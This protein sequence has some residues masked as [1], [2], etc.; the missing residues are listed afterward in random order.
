MKKH[1]YTQRL[2]FSS[3]LA[4]SSFDPEVNI[5]HIIWR[6]KRCG[7][8][9][10]ALRIFHSAGESGQSGGCTFPVKHSGFK[11]MIKDKQDSHLSS[12]MSYYLFLSLA[13]PWAPSP[14]APHPKR[15]ALLSSLVS[16]SSSLPCQQQTLIWGRKTSGEEWRPSP[17][18]SQHHPMIPLPSV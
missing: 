2:L 9:K 12:G 5:A 1:T 14:V 8:P 11:I 18:P 4:I 16:L 3:H 7:S 15:P 17:F 6:S 13:S 10:D